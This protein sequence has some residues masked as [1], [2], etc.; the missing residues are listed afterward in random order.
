MKTL[1]NITI[2]L[3]LITAAQASAQVSINVNIGTAPAWGPVGYTDVRY[4]YLPDV[5]MYYDINRSEY[6][7][8][9]N[10]GWVRT[11]VVPVAYSNYNFYNG[12][13]VVLT[14]YRG[15]TPYRYY[16]SHRVKYPRGYH[17]VAQRT[18]GV[19]PGHYRSARAAH[20][21]HRDVVVVK[22][23]HGHG[24]GHGHHKDHGHHNDHGRK[25]GHGRH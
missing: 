3:L 2:C 4:Y 10:G 8:L 17:P 19:P 24:R 25:N 15:G 11:A 14:D 22:N 9:N 12:Y 5:A 18:I 13:K 1:K 16:K 21:P 20:R 23:A 7:Y 6:I